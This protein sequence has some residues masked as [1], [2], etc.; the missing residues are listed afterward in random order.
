MKLP[1]A[2]FT[3]ITRWSQLDR[4]TRH[5]TD[6]HKTTHHDQTAA[7]AAVALLGRVAVLPGMPRG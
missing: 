4:S 2:A 6:Y 7:A 3:P 1:R 5:P